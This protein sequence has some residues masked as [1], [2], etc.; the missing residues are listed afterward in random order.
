MI[1]KYI[2]ER[3]YFKDKYIIVFYGIDGSGKSTLVKILSTM[4]RK[5]YYVKIIK[6]RGHHTVM[7]VIL[8]FLLFLKGL[9]YTFLQ[10]KLVYLNY[11]IRCYFKNKQLYIFL[12]ILGVIIWFFW[13]LLPNIYLCRNNKCVIIADRYLPDFAVLL[14]FTTEIKKRK[15][16]RIIKFL[17]KIPRI[18]PIYF[19]IYLNPKIALDRKKDEDLVISFC[20]FMDSRYQ[21]ISKQLNSIVINT[22]DR[23]PMDLIS[24]IVE[25]LKIYGFNV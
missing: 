4:L 9:N 22:S 21:Y 3:I 19:H 16:I 8:R 24:N 23:K 2:K 10:N 20:S 15:M 25:I 11:I 12:E 14:A 13:N 6:L 18:K 1:L 7:Y 5:N 17:E